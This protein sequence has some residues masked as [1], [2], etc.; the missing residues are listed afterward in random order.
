MIE[1][2]TRREND[3]MELLA[4]GYGMTEIAE[5]LVLRVSSVKTHYHNA[6]EKMNI[7][8]SKLDTVRVVLVLAYC[9]VN[10]ILKTIMDTK[11]GKY[12]R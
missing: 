1:P 2:L 4:H 7:Y 10:L 5:K 6:S 9:N 8:T 11:G 12:D 3:V